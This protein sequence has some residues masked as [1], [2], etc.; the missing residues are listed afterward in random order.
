MKPKHKVGRPIGSKIKT[1]ATPKLWH[2]SEAKSEAAKGRK[3]DERGYYLGKRQLR[4]DIVYVPEE[5]TYYL[6]SISGNG[7]IDEKEQASG[8][9]K[10]RTLIEKI[11]T[12]WRSNLE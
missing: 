6:T 12:N 9:E 7:E 1:G 8:M 5:Q 10:T 3:R 2:P 4:F 11:F